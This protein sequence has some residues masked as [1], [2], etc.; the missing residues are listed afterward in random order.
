M[1]FLEAHREFL[2]VV[3]GI[4]GNAALRLRDELARSRRRPVPTPAAEPTPAPETSALPV[5]VSKSMRLVVRQIA[6]AAGSNT[7]DSLFSGE[8][9]TGKE[10]LA[11][12][13]PRPELPPRAG[14]F[15]RLGCAAMPAG[16]HRGNALFGVQKGERSQSVPLQARGLFELCPGR[17]VVLSRRY[18]GAV[19]RPPRPQVLRVIQEGSHPTSGPP[20]DTPVAVDARVLAASRRPPWRKLVAQGEFLE[21]LYY[22]LS[23]FAHLCT[24]A[25]RPDGRY[26]APG[27]AVPGANTPPAHRQDRAPHLH[28]GHRSAQPVPLAR[29]CPGAGQLHGAGGHAVRRGRGAHVP[30]AAHAPD[31]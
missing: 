18:R 31:R 2:S 5:A 3:G 8:E 17:D 30:S 26:P 6:Q 24:P 22:A 15:Q 4:L 21:D 23:V 16:G 12:L 25:S 10:S 1:V 27:R 29:Q 11:Q 19:P 9:G 28:A 20:S 7:P 13:P 14:R